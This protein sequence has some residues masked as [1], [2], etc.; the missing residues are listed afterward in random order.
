MMPVKE[1]ASMMEMGTPEQPVNMML[2]RGDVETPIYVTAT[3][4]GTTVRH[5]D[6][7]LTGHGGWTDGRWS[8]VIARPFHLRL[9]AESIVPLA[10]G[11]AHI[12]TFAVWQGSDSERAGL[13]SYHP[14]WLPLEIAP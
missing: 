7:G 5:Q 2:W 4:R 6:A 3:G 8:V 14:Q 11:M 1:M 13:K 10:P 9:P 12:C